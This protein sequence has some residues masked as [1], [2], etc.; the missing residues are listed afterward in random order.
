MKNEYTIERPI[1]LSLCDLSGKLS[2]TGALDLFM[3]IATLHEEDSGFGVYNMLEKGLYWIVGKNRVHFEECPKMMDEVVI[4]TWFMTPSRL[5]VNRE[6]LVTDRDGKILVTGETE[7]LVATEN[8][9]KLVSVR[10]YIPETFL[11]SESGLFGSKMTRVDKD[12]SDAELAGRYTVSSV[13]VDFVGHMNNA[14][15]SRAIMS[16]LSGEELRKHP[17]S[18]AEIFYSLQC[19]EGDELSVY[20]RNTEGA[21]EMGAF[22]P[23]GTLV[24]TAR[25]RYGGE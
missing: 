11:Y 18:D 10:D 8:C 6:Y 13:D 7:W 14:A 21:V 19:K 9:E 1:L 3:D 16:F 24:M 12:F 20:R 17:I 2:V 5:Y 25:L 4:K 15:Y 22:L 23:G